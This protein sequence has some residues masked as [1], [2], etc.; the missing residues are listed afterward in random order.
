MTCMQV[1]CILASTSS[2]KT[3]E[4][5]NLFVPFRCLTFTT[6]RCNATTSDFPAFLAA[7]Q[8]RVA[9]VAGTAHLRSTPALLA[10]GLTQSRAEQSNARE[11]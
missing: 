10:V 2:L 4:S 8:A 7:R 11:T 3:F 1:T 5:S 6:D 9:L